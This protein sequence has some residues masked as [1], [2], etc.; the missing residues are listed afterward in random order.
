MPYDPNWPQHG[1]K[2]T[3]FQLREQCNGVAALIDNVP[4]G[5]PGADGAAGQPG[6]NGADGNAL[7]Q[8]AGS[9]S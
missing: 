8:F 4:A 5:P 2:L 6:T 1:E 9:S 3:S 7:Q